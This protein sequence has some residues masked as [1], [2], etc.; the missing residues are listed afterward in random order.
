MKVNEIF[1]SLQGE[2]AN[3]GRAAVFVR[4]SG[5]NLRC[6]FCDTNFKDYVDISEDRIVAEVRKYPA[7]LV[8]VTGGEPALQ[9]TRSLVDKLHLYGKTVAVETNGTKE[10]PP[11]VDWVTVSPKAAY[12]GKSG[13]PTLKEA[14]EVKVVFD[15]THE[16]SD[17]GIT[18]KHYYLQP[19]D[20]GN[21]TENKRIIEQCVEEIKRNPRWTLSLQTQ[22]II[23][24]R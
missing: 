17:F 4:L 14:D 24:V 20:T 10:L 12:V 5:C 6:P 22:K 1:Y 9:L 19:C 8:V 18:A 21:E 15:G 3:T 2:G 13:K 11:N 7:D 16:V 23:N